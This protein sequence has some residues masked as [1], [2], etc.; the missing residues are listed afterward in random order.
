MRLARARRLK[1]RAI[2]VAS[3][4]LA[5]SA[6]CKRH[7]APNTLIVAGARIVPATDGR[8]DDSAEVGADGTTAQVGLA[9]AAFMHDDGVSSHLAG[10]GFAGGN[11]EGFAGAAGLRIEA[12]PY[13]PLDT[14]EHTFVGRLGLDAHAEANPYAGWSA[15]ELPTLSL[16]YVHHAKDDYPWHVELMG[17]GAFHLAGVAVSDDDQHSYFVRPTVGGRGVAYG[18]FLAL[19]A[20]YAYLIDED[21]MHVVDGRFCFAGFFAA[22]TDLR[23][24]QARFDD[25]TRVPFQ[26]G[27]TLGIGLATGYDLP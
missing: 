10:H 7:R 26:I 2:V 11:G 15:L 8:P 23:V 5:T 1:A 16:G 22:C 4:L 3:V 21:N 25:E 13:G 19:E 24:L 18:D 14:E 12:G 6:G 20:R 9:G 27:I 17:Q